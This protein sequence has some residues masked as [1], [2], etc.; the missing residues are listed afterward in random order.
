MVKRLLISLASGS[1]DRVEPLQRTYRGTDQ[2][3]TARGCFS[4]AER[5]RPLPGGMARG[6]SLS[7]RA[8]KRQAPERSRYGTVDMC[9]GETFKA[10]SD[11]SRRPQEPLHMASVPQHS[12]SGHRQATR[13]GLSAYAGRVRSSSGPR[14]PARQ[15]YPRVE[16]SSSRPSVAGQKHHKS[17][18][19]S[20]HVYGS[21]AR[22][23]W[24]V[25]LRNPP[26]RTIVSLH[27]AW[28]WLETLR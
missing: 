18:L 6:D 9:R 4:S 23:L 12:V 22:P 7:W 20:T 21:V 19:S 24:L 26:A 11:R 25:P 3:P 17:L 16:E 14:C 10:L 28:Q 13:S 1:K 2:V 27:A 5:F 8:A 15:R